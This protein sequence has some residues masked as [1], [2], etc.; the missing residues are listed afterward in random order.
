MN[1]QVYSLNHKSYVDG[2]GER[3]VV[4]FQ[5]CTL[6][7]KGCQSK[8]LWNKTG[9]QTFKVSQ[10]AH[11]LAYHAREHKN[12]TISGGEAF[13]QPEALAELV[14]RLREL[15]VEHIIVYSGY[16]WEEL[17]D[18]KHPAF[19]WLK[20]ILENIDVL[21]DGRFVR[22]LDDTTIT[23]RGS[24]NQR[25]IDVQESLV[26]GEPVILD[27]DNEIVLSSDGDLILPAGFA[28]LFEEIGAVD[29]SRRC[30]QSK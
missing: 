6:A 1:I 18:Q 22:E 9:G 14:T 7:C 13:Q 2:P 11:A 4:F 28:N 27:W 12:V 3:A 30:G 26:A 19:P 15:G 20:T 24:R 23:Y 5:G 25:P 10:I 8:H 16:T 21:V 17:F 29:S